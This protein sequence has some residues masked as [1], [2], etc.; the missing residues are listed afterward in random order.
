M[1]TSPGRITDQRRPGKIVNRKATVSRSI[2]MRSTKFTVICATSCLNRD[3]ST[4]TTTRVSDSAPDKAGRRSSVIQKKFRMPQDR[5][6]QSR[7]LKSVSV[8][9][10]SAQR[11]QMGRGDGKQ[12]P[13]ADRGEAGGGDRCR[14]TRIWRGRHRGNAIQPRLYPMP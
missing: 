6:K 5:T 14:W 7:E 13:N 2:T 3:S 1:V 10:I 8:W 11:G 12:A 9:N 4:S